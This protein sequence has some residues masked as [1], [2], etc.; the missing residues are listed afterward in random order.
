MN[1]NFKRL[2]Q[3]NQLKTKIMNYFITIEKKKCTKF[4]ILKQKLGQASLK[5]Q[6]KINL[7]RFRASVLKNKKLKIKRPL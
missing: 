6:L 3:R 4:L 2:D 1:L 5:N 7:T